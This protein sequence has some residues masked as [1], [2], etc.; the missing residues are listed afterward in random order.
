MDGGAVLDL[1]AVHSS[2]STFAHLLQQPREKNSYV[3]TPADLSHSQ[4]TMEG[5]TFMPPNHRDAH[6]AR[7]T[8]RILK[9]QAKKDPSRL[10]VPC[11]STLAEEAAADKFSA[12]ANH[13]AVQDLRTRF[14]KESLVLTSAKARL[15]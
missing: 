10:H 8:R 15:S 12:G 4:A 2:W 14:L 3:Y 9:A 6:I 5:W 11:G 13:D 1:G 7:E